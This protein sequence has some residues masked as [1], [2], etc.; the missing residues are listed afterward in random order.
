MVIV[1]RALGSSLGVPGFR[2]SCLEGATLL[3]CGHAAKKLSPFSSPEGWCLGKKD[4]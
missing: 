4:P 2:G 1:P 3:M